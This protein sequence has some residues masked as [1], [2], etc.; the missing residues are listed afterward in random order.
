MKKLL[1]AAALVAASQAAMGGEFCND[2]R[3]SLNNKDLD[4]K[5]NDLVSDKF[6]ERYPHKSWWIHIY[7]TT[8]NAGS[9]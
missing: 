2:S 6:T 9:D 3:G 8:G 7:T 5:L 4:G 1:V